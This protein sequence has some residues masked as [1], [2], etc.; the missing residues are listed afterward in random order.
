MSAQPRP[1]QDAVSAGGVVWRRGEDGIEVV[2][3][4]RSAVHAARFGFAQKDQYL[5]VL[6][7]GTPDDGETIEETALR[8]VR[9]ETGLDV[10][11]GE[12]LGK[13]DY[14]F[15]AGGQRIHKRV[16]HWL[17]EPSGGDISGHDAEFDDVTWIP[18][19]EAIRSVTYANERNVLEEAARLIGER[20]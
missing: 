3:C 11:L 17:M 18:I 5:W 9:E 4:G 13:I 19:A 10:R 12:P 16:Y 14:W 6:P 15:A 8:E 7:K 2:L 20:A 1:V